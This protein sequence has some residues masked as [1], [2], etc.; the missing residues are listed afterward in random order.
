MIKPVYS[1]SFLL[2][3]NI[4]IW[5]NVLYFPNDLRIFTQCEWGRN[6]DLLYLTPLELLLF[7]GKLLVRSGMMQEV[8]CTLNRSLPYTYRQ[9]AAYFNS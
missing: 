1:V 6:A 4:F 2:S 8:L 3:I 9:S 5:P 7:E